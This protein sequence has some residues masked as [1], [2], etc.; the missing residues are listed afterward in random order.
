M[1]GRA[2]FLIEFSHNLKQIIY[3]L[4]PNFK[5]HIDTITLLSIIKS[6]FTSSK[7]VL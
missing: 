7:V 3:S 5:N 2:A 6:Q 1:T 4:P